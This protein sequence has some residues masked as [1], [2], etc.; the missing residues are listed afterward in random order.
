MA[1]FD[2]RFNMKKA[3]VF[4][5]L[6]SLFLVFSCTT[7]EFSIDNLKCE[8]KTNPIGVDIET[9]RFNWIMNSSQRGAYQTA[10]RIIVSSTQENCK[11]DVGDIWDSKKVDS[12]KSNQIYF[13]G[14]ELKSNSKYF[15]KVTVWNQSEIKSS[16]ELAFWTTGLLNETDWEAKWIGL[17][18]NKAD[19][20]LE[21]IHTK[22]NA[23]MLRYEFEVEKEIESA[24]AFISGLGLFEFYVNGEKI[25]DQV[26][27]P[28][29]TEYDKRTFYMTFD[30]SKN[31]KKGKNAIGVILGNGRYFGPRKNEPNR[32]KTY[33]FPK[34][35]SQIEIKYTDGT[36]RKI[37]SDDSWKLTTDG[38]TRENNEYDGEFY[39]ARKEL[40]GWSKSDFDDSAWINAKLVDKPGELLI[41]Q[42]NEPIR[43]IEELNPISVKEIE[44]GTFI[45]DMGQN[46]VGWT[47]LFVE[48]EKDDKVVLRFGEKLNDD[49]TIF[50]TNLRS[51]K[52]TD[53]YI[54]KGDGKESWEPKFTYHGFRFV[55]MKGYPG[56]PNLSSIKGKVIHDDLDLSGTFSTSNKTINQ[57]YKNAYWGIRGN[58]RSIP[59][60]CPQRDEKQ[61]WLGDRSAECIGESFIFN[62]PNFYNKWLVDI[63]DAQRESG[64]IP[65][66]APSYWPYYTDNT[67]WPGT[68]LFA[69]EMLY[70][71]YGDIGTIE[72]HY[73]NM[74]KWIDYM[75]QFLVDGLMQKDTYGDW[76]TPPQSLKLIQTNAPLKTTS[77]EYIGAAYFYYELKLMEKFALI[78]QKE[79][80][81]EKYATVAKK[82][83]M[84]FNETY[85]DKNVM[86]Y[87]NNS[88]TANILALKFDLVPLEYKEQVVDNLL[89]KIMGE[90]NYHIGNGII[91]GQ[92]LMRTL[93]DNGYADVAYT[94]AAQTTYPSWGYMIEKGA[95]TIWELWNGDTADPG[96]NSGNH[97]MLLGDLIIWYYESLAGIKADPENPGFKHIIMKPEIVGDLSFVDASYNSIYGKIESSWVID[98]DKFN[99][100]ITIPANTSATIYVPVSAEGDVFEGNTKA[101][102]SD[103]VTFMKREGDRAIFDIQ[104][105]TYSFLSKGVKKH[106]TEEYTSIPKITSA[107]STLIVGEKISIEIKCDDVEA[108]IRYTT[109]GHEPNENSEIYS[110]PL[111]FSSYTYLK[112]KAFSNDKKPSP[113]A[114]AIY[115]FIKP[116]K[117]GIS[118]EMYK[119]KFIEIPDLET[120]NSVSKGTSTYFDLNE[121]EVPKHEFVLKFDTRI[122]IDEEGDYYFYTSS[123]D[124]SKLFIDDKLVVNNDGLHAVREISG[125]I[126]LK[127]GRHKMKLEYFQEGG[128]YTLSVYYKSDEI[129][130]RPIPR[131]ILFKD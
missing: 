41:A 36:T 67:T 14:I 12:D 32:R 73:A 83:K 21:D 15:W 109:N 125:K 22:L 114:D 115:D 72:Y 86:K 101:S 25:G 85:L 60:D 16:S 58:Y 87:S 62:V 81:A 23:R 6:I 3:N 118:W 93:S 112:A 88:V 42:P 107:D 68:Y 76:C 35:I 43:I 102:N 28:G 124:G 47:E 94:L 34:L 52:V 95:T 55:E 37:I 51:S 128:T 61:G 98:D 30:V 113:T 89:Q 66:V 79:N 64:S 91:G 10:Y 104:P 53:T 131:S 122:Q 38:P 44:P 48:G 5:L 123:N 78:L 119:G 106:I 116:V 126:Y 71:Q 82:M 50:L 9:P 69:S 27:A 127:K 33:G 26:L 13:E 1:N 29:L 65:D 57:I 99:W 31:L 120:L 100:D 2:E 39:D 103:G 92:W 74:Q 121:I 19:I 110:K 45:F 90:N 97:V 111:N 105:G 46:M 84:A 20:D 17:D 54:L 70:N 117:N 130:Y 8:Y 80:D 77:S 63:K 56:I 24:T 59:T 4:Q 129:S 96:M 18:R 40:L 108:I 7:E 11:Q 75:S 49:G